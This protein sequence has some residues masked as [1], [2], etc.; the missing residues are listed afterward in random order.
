[1][2]GEVDLEARGDMHSTQTVGDGGVAVLRGQHARESIEIPGAHLPFVGVVRA[3]QQRPRAAS[4][5]TRK[6]THGEEVHSACAVQ[7]MPPS[8]HQTKRN[9]CSPLGCVPL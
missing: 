3:K 7:R 6:R 4:P 5:P 1:M 8:I 2:R 9:F